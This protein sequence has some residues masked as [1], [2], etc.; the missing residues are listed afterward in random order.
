LL[1][2]HWVNLVT[3]SNFVKLVVFARIYYLIYYII[4]INI[5]V[6]IVILRARLLPESFL[7]E[8]IIIPRAYRLLEIKLLE[9]NMLLEAFLPEI[10]LFLE[11][12]RFLESIY[13]I[14]RLY[15]YYFYF[16]SWPII[17][18]SVAIWLKSSYSRLYNI[19]LLI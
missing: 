16:S 2:F 7:L 8:V 12:Y 13:R 11:V 15:D 5:I 18:R 6:T 17:A 10:L 9:A 4:I 19:C 1:K 3:G 14:I